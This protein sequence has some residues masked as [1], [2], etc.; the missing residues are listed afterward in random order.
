MISATRGC[1]SVK[2]ATR[3]LAHI[4]KP[5]AFLATRSS[6]THG[7][8]LNMVE[9]LLA[10]AS[11]CQLLDQEQVVTKFFGGSVPAMVAA[12]ETSADDAASTTTRRAVE[13][14]LR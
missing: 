7:L 9:T 4:R 10:V 11:S 14:T 5:R 13:E 1:P 12:T 6:P 2:A 8:W 3:H